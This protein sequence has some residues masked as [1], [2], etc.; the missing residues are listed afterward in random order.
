LLVLAC[1]VLTEMLGGN[2]LQPMLM[3]KDLDVSLTSVTLSLLGWGFLLGPAGV[4]LSVPLTLALRRFIDRTG[5][6]ASP[7]RSPVAT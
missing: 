6:I 7:Q 2:V 3:K 4:I 1:L 5:L